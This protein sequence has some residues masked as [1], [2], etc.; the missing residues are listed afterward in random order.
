MAAPAALLFF[1]L[2]LLVA[3]AVGDLAD[4]V[5]RADAQAPP[6]MSAGLARALA[7]NER[8]TR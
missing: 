8:V 7:E 4:A 6:A 3:L 2:G 1:A 5:H